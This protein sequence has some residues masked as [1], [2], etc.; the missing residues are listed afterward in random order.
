MV[1]NNYTTMILN[2]IKCIYYQKGNIS[3]FFKKNREYYVTH[4]LK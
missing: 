3:A 4:S 2:Y 1:I